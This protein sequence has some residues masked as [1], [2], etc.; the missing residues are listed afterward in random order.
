MPCVY[1][2]PPA[3]VHHRPSSSIAEDTLPSDILSRLN[4]LEDKITSIN[5]SPTTTW[6]KRRR[7]P[8]Q[9]DNV[10]VQDD[11]DDESNSP[12][13]RLL[14]TPTLTGLPRS[15]SRHDGVNN[16][17]MGEVQLTDDGEN[18]STYFGPS[19]NVALVRQLSLALTRAQS[20]SSRS[21]VMPTSAITS[22]PSSSR[23]PSHQQS[24]RPSN[25]GV[26]DGGSRPQ[27]GIMSLRNQKPPISSSNTSALLASSSPL[28][29]KTPS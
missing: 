21:G 12:S 28:S 8:A 5:T 15:R 14:A 2:G 27:T 23:H 6:A 19:S 10:D 13:N 7:D 25:A 18:C 29:T 26:H 1:D 24:R 4:A 16:D 3:A 9:D 11:D 17:G 20:Q 22:V